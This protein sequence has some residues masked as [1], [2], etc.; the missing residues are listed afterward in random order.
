VSRVA[1]AIDISELQ[2]TGTIL[3]NK[4]TIRSYMRP[5]VMV[6]A[7]SLGTAST[8]GAQGTD[9]L[10]RAV[11]RVFESWRD[12]D[13]PGCAVGVSRDGSVVYERGYGMANLETDT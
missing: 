6:L 9:S 5:V 3:S 12:T 7:L 13:G 11:D 10:T 4:F 1:K 8:G 2:P